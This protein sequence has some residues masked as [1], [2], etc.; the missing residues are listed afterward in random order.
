MPSQSMVLVIMC[1]SCQLSTL[2]IFTKL[3]Q[4]AVPYQIH[5]ATGRFR[6]LPTLTKILARG[7]N[8]I[9]R[10]GLV[11]PG[12]TNAYQS[13]DLGRH[14]PCDSFTNHYHRGEGQAIDQS[15]VASVVATWA[16]W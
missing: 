4:E 11:V 8:A 13:R 9:G 10:L 3:Y 15:V 12:F 6:R 16:V 7:A 5:H 2:F 14:Q 1:V